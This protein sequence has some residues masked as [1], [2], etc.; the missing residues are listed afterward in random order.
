MNTDFTIKELVDSFAIKNDITINDMMQHGKKIMDEFRANPLNR[1]AILEAQINTTNPNYSLKK[2]PNA[3]GFLLSVNNTLT[4]FITMRD[5][6]HND[7]SE[8]KGLQIWEEITDF[9]ITYTLAS[10]YCLEYKLTM[11]D[12]GFAITEIREYFLKGYLQIRMHD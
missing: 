10:L 12:I 6:F 8:E 5:Y 11:M 7:K 2:Y 3:I 9:F 1:E 4:I